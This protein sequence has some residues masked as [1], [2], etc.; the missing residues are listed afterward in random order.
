MTMQVIPIMI[1]APFKSSI[2]EVY[3]NSQHNCATQVYVRPGRNTGLV[4]SW[5]IG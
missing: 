1:L 3:N 5:L 2:F 4:K